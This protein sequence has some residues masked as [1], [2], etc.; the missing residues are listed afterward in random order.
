MLKKINLIVIIRDWRILQMEGG[1]T[2]QPKKPLLVS[3]MIKKNQ[4]ENIYYSLEV[5]ESLKPKLVKL[6]HVSN[7]AAKAWLAA[8]IKGRFKV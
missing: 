8:D 5:L 1:K 4:V 6:K 2:D 7:P 3:R